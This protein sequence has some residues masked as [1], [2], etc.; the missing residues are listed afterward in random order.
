MDSTEKYIRVEK[1]AQKLA[2]VFARVDGLAAQPVRRENRSVGGDEIRDFDQG[3][4]ECL[5]RAFLAG[6]EG[7]GQP[8][9][10]I[11]L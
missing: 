9:L 7:F 5:S 6:V 11:R 1:D 2:L 3:A 8:L 10:K 4:F